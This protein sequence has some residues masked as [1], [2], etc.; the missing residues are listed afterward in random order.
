MQT[1]IQIAAQPQLLAVDGG[2]GD[3]LQD[4]R[5]VAGGGVQRNGGD[6]VDD[7]VLLHT[8]VEKEVHGKLK[9]LPQ[10]A[11]G[12]GKAK[13]SERQE[14]GREVEGQ[15]HVHGQTWSQLGT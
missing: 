9:K 12:H 7:G 3:I 11:D 8:E 13:G 15:P 4:H 1:D 6:G 5:P 14:K 10:H 2:G